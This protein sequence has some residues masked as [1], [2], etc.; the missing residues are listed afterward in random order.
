MEAMSLGPDIAEFLLRT[1]P[2]CPRWIEARSMLL[3][4]D[5]RIT[6]FDPDPPTAVIRNCYFPV[7]S[8]IGSPPSLEIHRAA[9]AAGPYAEVLAPS[10]LRCSLSDDP[11]WRKEEALLF[12]RKSNLPRVIGL[13]SRTVRY[14]RPSDP[15]DHLSCSLKSELRTA[16][17][18]SRV[19]AAFADGQPV[20]F[21]YAGAR[22]ETLWD[23]AVDTVEGFRRQGL[24][25]AVVSFLIEEFLMKGLQPVWGARR[26]N[27]PSI[28]LAGKLGFE[29]VDSLSLF[30]KIIEE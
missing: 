23:V 10:D 25:A 13:C 17:A 15:L 14:L 4:G 9:A 6:Y 5:G 19:A 2:D 16:Q 24:A 27:S 3:S 20:S 28:N 11:G 21:C 29:P 7:V 18:I 26:S 8:I 12:R 30:Q 22:T 1:I